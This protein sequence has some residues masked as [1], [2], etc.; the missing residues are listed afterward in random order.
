MLKLKKISKTYVIGDFKQNALDDISVEFRKAEFVTVL[1]PS[2][3]GK[4]TMLNVIGGL[5]HADKG[6]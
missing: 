3:C 6:I 1:G 5:D 4:T 2:G